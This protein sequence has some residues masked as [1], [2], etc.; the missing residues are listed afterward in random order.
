MVIMNIKISTRKI[1][2]FLSK[3]YSHN[4]YEC[5]KYSKPGDTNVKSAMKNQHVGFVKV[6][7]PDVNSTII[8]IEYNDVLA[9]C[10]H[11]MKHAIKKY[12]LECNVIFTS[13]TGDKMSVKCCRDNGVT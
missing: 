2:F 5:Y 11:E 1:L 12:E 13:Q 3:Q 8:N 6:V 9:L 4:L 7:Q 10:D